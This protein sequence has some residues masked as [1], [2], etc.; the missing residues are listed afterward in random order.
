MGQ[1]PIITPEQKIILAGIKEN[2]FIRE[3]F[4]FTGGTALAE[5]YLQHRYSDDLDFFSE[6]QFEN[7]PIISFIKDLGEK[8]GFEFKS[9]AIETVNIFYL[10]FPNK[11]AIKVDFNYYPFKRL[12]NSLFKEGVYVDSL[13]DMAVN[14]LM[15]IVQRANVKDFVDFY[16]LEPKFG[17]WDLMEGVRVKFH[18]EQEP[19]L[20]GSD[21]LKIEDFEI[22]PRMIKPVSLVELKEFYRELAR[23]VGKRGV[24]S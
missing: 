18:Q 20:L 2:S 12:E 1:I 4:Y 9:E 23:K 11:P 19:Y 14:K 17:V 21:F 16:F 8:Q 6:N 13:L 22:L 7:Q 24:R 3:N 10:S 15:T 5:F